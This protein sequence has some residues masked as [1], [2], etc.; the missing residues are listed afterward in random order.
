LGEETSKDERSKKTQLSLWGQLQNFIALL[1]AIIGVVAA[2][3]AFGSKNAAD[4]SARSATEAKLALE[5]RANERAERET[6]AKLDAIAYEAVVK[7]LELDRTNLPSYLAEK[8]ERAVLALVIVTASDSMKQALLDVLSS[9]Q[10]VSASVKSQAEQTVEVLREFGSLAS[11]NAE[12]Y[13]QTQ[14]KERGEAISADAGRLLKGFRVVVFNC[15][16]STNRQAEEIQGAAVKELLDELKSS[17]EISPLNIS[18]ST[19][20]IPDVLNSSPGYNIQTNQIRFNP[21][22]AED[23]P[24]LALKALLESTATAK[25]L[26]LSFERRAVAQRTP[27]YLSVFLCG[28]RSAG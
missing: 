14:P 9:G 3:Q 17:A 7:V 12:I 13:P 10:S 4:L 19:K 8:R 22:D 16:N 21:A 5:M 1:S 27:G 23:A 11:D 26:G 25:S 15:Q 6:K 18:W 20:I 2:V 24:S 28:V